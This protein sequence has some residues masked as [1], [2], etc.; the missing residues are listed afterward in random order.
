VVAVKE[1]EKIFS[2]KKKKRK[3]IQPL[4]KNLHLYTSPLIILKRERK[5]WKRK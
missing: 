2:K 4:L 1:K 3:T 5:K